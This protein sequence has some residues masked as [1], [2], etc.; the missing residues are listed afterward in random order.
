A[1]SAISPAADPLLR[2]YDLQ[3]AQQAVSAVPGSAETQSFF[4]GA[5]H[6]LTIHENRTWLGLSLLGALL[7]LLFGLVRAANDRMVVRLVR[8][9]VVIGLLAAMIAVLQRATGT[10]R[11]YGF[12]Q[13][14]QSVV[15][16][17]GPFVNRNHFAGWM[18]MAIPLVF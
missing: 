16:P 12:W 17:F 13:P 2:Q 11:I 10:T 9:L 18:L 1:L 3:Y 8:A 4:A 5:F 6:P 15:R 7:L 14:R